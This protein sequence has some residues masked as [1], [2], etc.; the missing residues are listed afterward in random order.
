[1]DGIADWLN[2]LKLGTLIDVFEDQQIDLEAARE[3]SE[4]DLKELDIP[5]GP[6]KKLLRAIDTLKSADLN[7]HQV[8]NQSDPEAIRESQNR[9]VTVLFADV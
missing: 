7:S 5:M 9:Q 6:R 1:M 4:A 8:S 3:L 2:S